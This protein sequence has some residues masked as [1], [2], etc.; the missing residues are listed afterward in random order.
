V[1]SIYFVTAIH[2]EYKKNLCG[3]C[4]YHR[5]RLH[6]NLHHL[7]TTDCSK[8]NLS[9]LLEKFLREVVETILAPSTDHQG[10][11]KFTP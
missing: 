4:V 1:E 7:L 8:K 2:S 5:I 10:K 9:Y 3:L 6:Q 11:M